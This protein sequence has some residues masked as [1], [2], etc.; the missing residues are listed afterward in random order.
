MVTTKMMSEMALMA[1][2][3]RM[4]FAVALETAST[5]AKTTTTYNG[6]SGGSYDD[7]RNCNL[8][9]VVVMVPLSFPSTSKYFV[10]LLRW[11]FLD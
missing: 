9:N 8:Y 4:A 6:T 11:L 3:L 5:K 10:V 2:I 7:D 1:T